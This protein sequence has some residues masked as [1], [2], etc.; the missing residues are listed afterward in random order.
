ML[1]MMNL[2]VVL[3]ESYFVSSTIDTLLSLRVLLETN[4]RSLNHV[5]ILYAVRTK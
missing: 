5:L 3:Q 2:R 1:V 4:K